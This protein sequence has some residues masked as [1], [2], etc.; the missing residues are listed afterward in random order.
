MAHGVRAGCAARACWARVTWRRA[1][2][3]AAVLR[4]HMHCAVLPL[5]V[6]LPAVLIRC[7]PRRLGY[8]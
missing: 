1:W 8:S 4:L 7:S 6:Q 3:L 2:R 5:V